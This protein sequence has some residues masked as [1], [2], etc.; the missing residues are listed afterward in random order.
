MT[1]V[2]NID[3]IFAYKYLQSSVTSGQ[4]PIANN[5]IWLTSPMTAY[6]YDQIS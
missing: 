1:N 4:S 5:V 2:P 3:V 6:F